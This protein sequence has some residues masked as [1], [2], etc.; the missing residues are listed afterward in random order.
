MPSHST[1]KARWGRARHCNRMFTQEARRQD[2]RKTIL[3]RIR[4]GVCAVPIRSVYQSWNGL[5][6]PHVAS[7]NRQ[8]WVRHKCSWWDEG[9]HKR[10]LVQAEGGEQGD[11]LMPLLFSIGIQGALEEVSDPGEQ[12]CAF[13]DDIYALCQPRRVEK[14]TVQGRRHP[15]PPRQDQSVE[16]RKCAT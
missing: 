10:T 7:C 2:A 1:V 11:L 16:Q 13:L 4:A 12:L 5:C 15:A 3:G 14:N 6:R 9:G 8:G